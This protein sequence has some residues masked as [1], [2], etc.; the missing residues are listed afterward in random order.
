MYPASARDRGRWFDRAKIGAGHSMLCPYK[1][2]GESQSA[3]AEAQKPAW[4][5]SPA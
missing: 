3:G 2:N 1:G 4:G 5:F